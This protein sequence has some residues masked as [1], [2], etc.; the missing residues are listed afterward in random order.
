MSFEYAQFDCMYYSKYHI[1][2]CVDIQDRVFFFCKFT[3]MD[4]GWEF[5]TYNLLE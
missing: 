2:Y 3:V 5:K 1:S 4:V